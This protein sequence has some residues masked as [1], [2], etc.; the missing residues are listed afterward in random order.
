MYVKY[1][2]AKHPR[3][4][5]YTKQLT[6]NFEPKMLEE[7]KSIVGKGYQV[8]IRELVQMYIDAYKRKMNDQR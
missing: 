7:F 1:K 4:Q 8:K 3:P 2:P 5:I 6:M